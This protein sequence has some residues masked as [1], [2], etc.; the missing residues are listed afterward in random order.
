MRI[1]YRIIPPLNPN[2]REFKTMDLPDQ[3]TLHDFLMIFETNLLS[4]FDLKAM[5]ILVNEKNV[6]EKTRLKHED[7]I[8]ILHPLAGG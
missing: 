6:S 5:T 1:Y 4:D 8:Y 2:D 3:S 7:L